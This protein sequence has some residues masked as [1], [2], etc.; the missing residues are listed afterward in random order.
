[1]DKVLSEA[2]RLRTLG[3]AVHWLRPASKIP[4]LSDWARA[5]VMAPEDLIAT[6]QQGYNLGFRPGEWS[7]VNGKEICVLD[8]DIRGGP[9]FAKEAYAAAHQMLGD[10]QFDVLSGS[11]V[12]RH[13]YLAFPIGTSPAKAAT[14]L[15]QSDIYVD[16]DSGKAALAGSP[17]AK[18]AWVIEILS[19]GKNVVMP[20]SVHPDT[21]LPYQWSAS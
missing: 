17:N 9:A 21:Q 12:G 5:P 4:V 20:P 10:G 19:T 15:R 6:Y 13:R 11:G 3:F 16:A 8:I 2:V 7:V 14:T 1:M 18:P